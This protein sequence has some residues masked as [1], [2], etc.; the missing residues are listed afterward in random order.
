MKI[1]TAYLGLGANLDAPV[2]QI[3]EALRLLQA[4]PEVHSLVSS[5]LYA[6]KP[7]GPQ[8]QP[9]YVNAVCRLEVSLEPLALL[10]LCQNIEMQ[11]GRV[12]KRHWGERTMDVDILLYDAISLHSETLT[13]PHAQMHL[14]DFVLVPLAEIAPAID[15]PG[16][17]TIDTLLKNLQQ[18]FLLPLAVE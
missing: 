8:D 14:R 6:S 15:I 9:D 7:L 18:S 11:L 5:Q 3:K 10:A 2:Q 4:Q 17:G 12:R 1:H 16:L 13:I